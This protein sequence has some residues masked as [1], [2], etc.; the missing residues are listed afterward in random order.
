MFLSPSA[1]RR[2]AGFAATGPTTTRPQETTRTDAT[3][4]PQPARTHSISTM[5]NAWAARQPNTSTRE[6]SGVDEFEE[7]PGVPQG[8]MTVA[9]GQYRHCRSAGRRR[10]SS[11]H[12]SRP[13]QFL[14]R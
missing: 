12:A 14:V 3:V 5:D 4:G 10:G 11:L 2:L 1:A 7:P 6:D 8:Y 13:A 9:I